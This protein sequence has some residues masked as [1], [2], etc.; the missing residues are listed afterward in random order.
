[1]EALLAAARTGDTVTMRADHLLTAVCILVAAVAWACRQQTAHHELRERSKSPASKKRRGSGVDRRGS[2]PLLQAIGVLREISEE[3]EDNSEVRLAVRTLIERVATRSSTD[4]FGDARAVVQGVAAKEALGVLQW[5][6]VVDEAPS[7][8]HRFASAARATM[9]GGAVHP[10]LLERCVEP[11]LQRE[12]AELLEHG[13]AEWEFDALR[14]HELTQ[15]RA[16]TALGW[17]LFERHDLRRNCGVSSAAV[18]DFFSRLEGA[19]RDV[20][21]HNSAHA[22]CVTHGLH[23]ILLASGEMLCSRPLVA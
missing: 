17:A 16:L 19:Y 21:Y 18:L 13:V 12:L 20:A 7:Q 5:M 9:L 22:A 14:L 4:R 15:G 23:W 8:L 1:M 11:P 10:H 3:E 2:N 6:P